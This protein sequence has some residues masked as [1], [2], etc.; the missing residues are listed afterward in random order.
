SLDLKV[1]YRAKYVDA[2]LVG[3]VSKEQIDVIRFIEGVSMVEINPEMKPM[4]DVSAKAIKARPTN[5]AEDGVK[6]HDVWEEL[7]FNGTGTNIA[8]LD[9]GANDHWN[10]W[11]ESLDDMDDDLLTLFDFKFIAG[12]DFE[13]MSGGTAVNPR[14]SGLTGHGTHCAG[15]ALGTGGAGHGY[16][17][18][19]PGARL[20]DVKVMTDVGAGGIPLPAIEWCIDNRDTDWENDGPAND[21]IHVMS[22]SIGGPD[23]NGDDA[24]SLAVNEAA[25]NGIVVVAAMGNNGA[26]NVP[27]P[28]AA[29]GAIAVAACND[30]NTVKRDDDSHA[31]YSN[32]GPR[33]D[34]ALK[35][36]ITAPGT[37]IFSAMKDTGTGYVAMDGTSMSCPHI[38]G[39]AALMLQANTDLTPARVKDIL[40]KTAEERGSHHISP[41]EP[42]YDTHWGW[43]YVDAY[44][45]VWMAM[46][47]PDLKAI[48]IQVEP[49]EITEDE[50][51]QIRAEIR[52]LNDRDVE[53]DIR[54]YDV[55]DDKVITTIHT[56]F[57]GGAT[58]VFTSGNFTAR[59]GDRTFRVEILNTEPPEEDTTNNDLTTTIYVNYRPEADIKANR[60]EARTGEHIT[61]NGSD[62]SDRDGDVVSFNF[63]FG[64]GEKT[65]WQD[66]PTSEHSYEDDGKYN[67][68]LMVKDGQDAE[69]GEPAYMIV[70]VENRAPKAGAG[71]NR[72][73]TEGDE[74]EFNGTGQDEDGTIALYEWDF[75][76]NGAYDWNSTENGNTTHTYDEEGNYTA[77]LR[78]TDDD[79]ATATDDREIEVREA[80]EPNNPP[81]AEISSPEEGGIYQLE[82]P[83]TFDGSESIDPDGDRLQFSWT[84]NGHE[85]GDEENFTA[86]LE[87]GDHIIILQVDDGRGCVDTESVRIYV[88]SPPVARIKSPRDD[89]TYYTRDE[90]KFD[91]S[92]SSDPDDDS[93]S[94][95]WTDNGTFLSGEETFTSRLKEGKHTIELSVDDGQGASDS[96][97]IGIQVEVAP[98]NPPIANI[99]SP[100]EGEVFRDIEE[101]TFDS[102]GSY[103]PDGD[104]ITFEWYEG[105]EHISEKAA[106]SRKLPAGEHKIHLI[107]WDENGDNGHAYVNIT[108]TENNLPVARIT[109][110]EDGAVYSVGSS[111]HFDGSHSSDADGDPLTFSWMDGDTEISTSAQFSEF[112]SLGAHTIC[113]TVD[114]GY[115]S[116]ATRV[117]IRVNRKPAAVISSP[118]DGSVFFSDQPVSFN[119]SSSSDSDGKIVSY[120]WYVNDEKIGNGRT[121]ERV[122]DTGNH[123]ITLT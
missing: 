60:T 21:G 106:F 38:A 102:S 111:I 69:S 77:V 120:T 93:L 68:T 44:E 51:M 96:V 55:T 40:H 33:G 11:H 4:L 121:M 46:G 109:S 39:V 82:D 104:G 123:E 29:N 5:E 31:S 113:L 8:V 32:H 73:A 72:T 85:F 114:D 10:S 110:P 26:R 61:F 63:D 112:L 52:E 53:A 28:A 80:G 78:V 88:N 45:A 81:E 57:G 56:S 100:S 90:I 115:N 58:K 71:S 27:T 84:D 50:Q 122:L 14:D 30:H 70:T 98:N 86:T 47:A 36:D 12:W 87:G 41:S 95:E 34:G 67:V 117:H 108:V 15:V 75:D 17:G 118:S 92:T 22:M 107:V 7:G 9:T 76:G 105:G 23:S 74:V 37:A 83:I 99:S 66:D 25:E 20:V 119:A 6:Y 64:D 16:S 94:Y 18:I 19:A 48:S 59:P 35:P 24:I 54:F 49:D 1:W 43:G 116:T 79:G 62:S 42:K 89:E 2:L 97:S 101:V 103:D 91:A 65:G 13:L 3:H